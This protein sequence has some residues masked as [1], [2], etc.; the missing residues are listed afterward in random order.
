MSKRLFQ[1]F[2]SMY[3]PG[4]EFKIA[5]IVSRT[6]WRCTNLVGAAINDDEKYYYEVIWDNPPE[7]WRSK[8]GTPKYVPF[9]NWVEL[10]PNVLLEF[11]KEK[12][13]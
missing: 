2:V 1:T 13:L 11:K 7:N 10:Y 9:R 8:K 3:S 6:V 12:N 4:G 5:K